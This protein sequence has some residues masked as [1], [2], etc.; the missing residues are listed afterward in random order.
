MDQHMR[1]G[2]L[3]CVEIDKTLEIPMAE[4]ISMVSAD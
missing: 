3:C 1:F 2:S 4:A